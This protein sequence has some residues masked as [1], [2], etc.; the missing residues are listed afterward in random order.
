MKIKTIHYLNGDLL[1]KLVIHKS[2]QA[3]RQANV[4]E[5]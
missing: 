4:H 1:H 2:Q 5:W 3:G